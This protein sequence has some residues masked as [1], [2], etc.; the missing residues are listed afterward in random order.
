MFDGR[1][2]VWYSIYGCIFGWLILEEGWCRSTGCGHSCFSLGIGLFSLLHSLS[3][4][5]YGFEMVWSVF[6]SMSPELTKDGTDLVGHIAR[7]LQIDFGTRLSM[8]RSTLIGFD[9][10][11]TPS[12]DSGAT[13]GTSLYLLQV[14]NGYL[15]RQWDEFRLL[16]CSPSS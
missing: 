11:L 12:I 14:I 6:R 7:I 16:L 1:R 2:N 13:S 9:A 3:K 10:M 8:R 15:V 4:W 5:L